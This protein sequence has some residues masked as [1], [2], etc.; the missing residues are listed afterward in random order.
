MMVH[1]LHIVKITGSASSGGN[2]HILECSHLMQHVALQLT[3]SRLAS[4]GK[5]FADA[6]VET[7]FDEVVHVDKVELEVTG[8]RSSERGLSSSHET[9]KEDACHDKQ[10]GARSY[11]FLAVRG[12][13]RGFFDDG[14]CDALA[15]ISLHAS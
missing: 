13:R 11:D 7:V 1:A 4:L 3:E 9:D 14:D 15:M 8:Q 12:E 6:L 2:D 5:Q 10:G